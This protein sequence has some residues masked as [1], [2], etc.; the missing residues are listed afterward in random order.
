MNYDLSLLEECERFRHSCSPRISYSYPRLSPEASLQG[1][2]VLSYPHTTSIRDAGPPH[3]VKVTMLGSTNQE[4]GAMAKVENE[5]RRREQIMREHVSK[6]TRQGLYLYDRHITHGAERTTLAR[7]APWVARPNSSF[8]F[9]K[10][11]PLAHLSNPSSTLET[12]TAIK[13]IMSTRFGSLSWHCVKTLTSL[14]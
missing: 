14:A 13:H 5:Q 9:H 4:L 7:C 8:T 6:G 3:S 12:L 10:L 11:E 1:Q 2:E